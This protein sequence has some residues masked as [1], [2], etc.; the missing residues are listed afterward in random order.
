MTRRSAEMKTI[1]PPK[2][3]NPCPVSWS[4]MSGD[5][6]RRLCQQ[7][8]CHVH[9]LTE[10]TSTEREIILNKEGK[11]CV[12]YQTDS[13]GGLISYGDTHSFLRFFIR[14]RRSFI[15]LMVATLPFALP[16][17]VTRFGKPTNAA[18][19][20]NSDTFPTYIMGSK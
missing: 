13:K 7:C 2:I 17:C 10:M 5:S 3:K 9:D 20:E 12:K 15:T 6:K 19:T 18:S 16:S 11:I 1:I 14:F 4:E 8:S